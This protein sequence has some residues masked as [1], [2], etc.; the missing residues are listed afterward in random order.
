MELAGGATTTGLLQQHDCDPDAAHASAVVAQFWFTATVFA[1]FC[2]SYFYAPGA[3]LALWNWAPG[4]RT[5][6]GRGEQETTAKK[7]RW[8]APVQ[9]MQHVIDPVVNP[10]VQAALTRA[11]PLAIKRASAFVN[12]DK[13]RVEKVGNLLLD[14]N[15]EKKMGQCLAGMFGTEEFVSGFVNT[16]SEELAKKRPGLELGREGGAGADER[17]PA[18]PSD[19]RFEENVKRYF[20][21]AVSACVA[22][23][24]RTQPEWWR[25]KLDHNKLRY[26]ASTLG[27]ASSTLA[28]E[29]SRLD[30]D[31]PAAAADAFSEVVLVKPDEGAEGGDERDERR[32]DESHRPMRAKSARRQEVEG[33]PPATE[34]VLMQS[35]PAGGSAASAAGRPRPEEE[36]GLALAAAKALTNKGKNKGKGKDQNRAPVDLEV[37]PQQPPPRVRSH[38]SSVSNEEL[39][40]VPEEWSPSNASLFHKNKLQRDLQRRGEAFAARAEKLSRIDFVPSPSRPVE[41]TSPDDHFLLSSPEAEID[42]L[43]S[44]RGDAS[45]PHQGTTSTSSKAD[46]PAPPSSSRPQLQKVGSSSSQSCAEED[47]INAAKG[48]IKAG[49]GF[50]ISASLSDLVVEAFNSKE[51]RRKLTKGAVA[52]IVQGFKEGVFQKQAPVEQWNEFFVYLLFLLEDEDFAFAAMQGG[53]DEMKELIKDIRT[54]EEI[55]ANFKTLLRSTLR[56]EKIHKALMKGSWEA[57]KSRLNPL[58]ASS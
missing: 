31:A 23:Y 7:K 18:G 42:H 4:V 46:E 35:Q 5:A 11:F 9:L 37:P 39:G 56:D 15:A 26:S 22:E 6:A 32:R 1:M 28:S 38:S 48:N 50:S 27:S 55:S 12:A 57:M 2:A 51:T 34:A 53:F 10:M 17:C 14:E 19:V 30:S 45:R 54:D 25:E 36:E 52:A 16:F 43:D 8:S 41:P 47:G 44:D 21:Q 29:R 13:E 3:V 24:E 20:V 33:A 40:D 49:R 58:K